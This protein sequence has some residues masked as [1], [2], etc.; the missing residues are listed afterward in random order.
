M[1]TNIIRDIILITFKIMKI[2]NEYQKQFMFLLFRNNNFIKL[3][4]IL[5][6]QVAIKKFYFLYNNLYNI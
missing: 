6:T 1:I 2:M 5:I 3:Y 4:K